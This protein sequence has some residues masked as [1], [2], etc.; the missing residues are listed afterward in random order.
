MVAAHGIQWKNEYGKILEV[1]I[2]KNIF[3]EDIKQEL[4]QTLTNPAASSCAEASL[5]RVL[6]KYDPHMP[7]VYLLEEIPEESI[8]SVKN[9]KK[10]SKGKRVRK[11]YLCKD[12]GTGKLYL[13]SP[14]AEVKLIETDS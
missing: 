10:Y 9:G 13:F 3:P 2:E 12:M 1:F 8:F 14:V 4:L 7:G 5:L 6:R 11:R